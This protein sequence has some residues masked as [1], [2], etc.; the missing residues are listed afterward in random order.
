M[1]ARRSLDSMIDCFVF[2]ELRRWA[3]KMNMT[4][5]L[6]NDMVLVIEPPDQSSNLD[7]VSSVIAT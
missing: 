1:D 6:S 3:A 2:D 5:L 4:M 7:I